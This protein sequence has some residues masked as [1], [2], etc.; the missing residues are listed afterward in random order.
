MLLE[1]AGEI[2]A[3][4]EAGLSET[5]AG[6]AVESLYEA[7]RLDIYYYLVC[8]QIPPAEAQELTQEAFLRLLK[9]LRAGEE[10]ANPKAWVYT[11]ARNLALRSRQKNSR[12]VA[13]EGDMFESAAL[14]PE[15]VLA[16]KERT[17][18]LADAIGSLSGRQRLCLHL[19]GEG[20]RYVE[21]AEAAGIST[22]AVG[23]F[24]R[25]AVER[26]RKV[27]HE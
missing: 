16:K 6:E 1:A 4:S 7:N 21:I 10:I 24:L 14:D 12:A 8:M 19:R 13:S 18:R 15:Q 17:R 23:E 22:S 25:R 5:P 20:L 2:R 26:L 11:V 3:K 9:S 27:L